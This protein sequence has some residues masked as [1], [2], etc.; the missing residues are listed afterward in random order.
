M[1]SDIRF[2]L[3]IW[4][5]RPILAAA[6][7]FTL[8]LGTGAN[9]AIFSVI[10]AVMLKPL[11]YPEPSRLVQVWSA[12]RDAKAPTTISDPGRQ[13]TAVETVNQWR[14]M[15][16]PF[17]EMGCYRAWQYTLSGDRQP[18]RVLSVAV[19]PGFLHTLGLAP[20]RGRAF[21]A[22]EYTIGKEHA[23]ILSDRLWRR[24]F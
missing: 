20:S 2:A 19:S 8:A 14:Q 13:L 11:P 10:Y 23:V 4:R 16:T 7:L 17:E 3:R 6:A 18:E 21:T 1:Y 9:V 15:D 22:D 5:R 12:I 24:W